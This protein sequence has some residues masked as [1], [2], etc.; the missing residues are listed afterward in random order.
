MSNQIDALRNKIIELEKYFAKR[1]FTEAEVSLGKFKEEDNKKVVRECEVF[2]T[3]YGHSDSPH[4]NIRKIFP[5]VEGYQAGAKGCFIYNAS[6]EY[7]ILAVSKMK[8]LEDELKKFSNTYD[9]KISDAI[10]T[11]NEFLF[12]QNKKHK[13]SFEISFSDEDKAI[14][15]HQI[16]VSLDG[17]PLGCLQDIKL[18][19]ST[20]EP[21]N[22]QFILPSI[23]Y[24]T[25]F[26]TE[27]AKTKEKLL[28]IPRA[29]VSI[30]ASHSELKEIGTNGLIDVLTPSIETKS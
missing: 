2:L 16:L 27:I 21:V 24:P 19:A 25:K 14:L 18:H 1:Y 7:R 9:D 22:L 28:S 23:E 12:S 6:L 10:N 11:A 13:L 3:Y 26:D 5:R 30:T 8:E 20:N 4:F 15:P 17:N 29:V